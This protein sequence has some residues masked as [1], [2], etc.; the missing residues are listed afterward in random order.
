[1]PGGHSCHSCRSWL[2]LPL[3]RLLAGTG[4]SQQRQLALP[5]NSCVDTPFIRLN[6]IYY[7]TG[8]MVIKTIN[9]EPYT[10]PTHGSLHFDS[11]ISVPDL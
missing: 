10:Y 9:M 2:A 8:T 4:L 7:T 6:G 11:T 3:L 1:M 5:A